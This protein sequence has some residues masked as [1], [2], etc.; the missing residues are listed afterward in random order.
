MMN[1]KAFT[2][3]ELL[4]VVLIIGILAAIALP[5]YEKAV[6][7]SRFAE[8]MM[9]LKTIYEADKACRLET[10]ENCHITDLAA[11]PAGQTYTSNFKIGTQPSGWETENFIY[12]GSD[13][14]QDVAA[15]ADVAA[16]YK[17]EDVCLCLGENGFSVGTSSDCGS[18]A[19]TL[20]YNKLLGISADCECC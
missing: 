5:K 10:G 12:I 7:K 6:V 13:F 15:E 14:I 16:Y 19:A 2:L 1:K 8:A 17:K 20:D 4:V 18:P 3:I 11:L 9:N